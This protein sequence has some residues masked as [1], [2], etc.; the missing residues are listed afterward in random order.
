MIGEQNRDNPILLTSELDKVVFTFTPVFMTNNFQS[1]TRLT[2]E[3]SAPDLIT[4]DGSKWSK[5]TTEQV[6]KTVEKNNN[7]TT[8]TLRL[9]RN[10]ELVNFPADTLISTTGTVFDIAVKYL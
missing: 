9:Y 3:T 7:T 2:S 10:N 1:Y 8:M 5:N 6:R 4:S